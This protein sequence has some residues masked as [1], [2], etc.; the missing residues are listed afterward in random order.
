V[1]ID[2]NGLKG[3]FESG[4]AP[5]A[6]L[7][8]KYGCHTDSIRRKAK[9]E[10]WEKKY[11]LVKKPGE[12]RGIELEGRPERLPERHSDFWKGVEKRLARGLK[13]RDVKQGLEELK[14]AKMAGEVISSM[15]RGKRLELGLEEAAAEKGDDEGDLVAAEMARV[16]AASGA[17]EALD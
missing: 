16:T 14:V 15:I 17:E 1:G 13:T 2:W 10:G 8:K 7:A 6:A 11:A 12:E 3:E 9:K 4:S 5:T